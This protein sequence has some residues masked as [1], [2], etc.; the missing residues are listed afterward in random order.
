MVD[1]RTVL[2]ITTSNLGSEYLVNLRE[3]EDK[4]TVGK[5]MMGVARAFPTRVP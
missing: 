4:K 2:I 3:A 1:F 5:E